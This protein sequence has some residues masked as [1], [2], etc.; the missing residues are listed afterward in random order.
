MHARAGP[1]IAMARH[2]AG[3]A[4]G[5]AGRPPDDGPQRHRLSQAID[6]RQR[7]IDLPVAASPRGPLAM[8]QGSMT[9]PP[10]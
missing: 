3:P 6:Q 8:T 2:A 4:H 7:L 9:C 10:T 1:D 5:V